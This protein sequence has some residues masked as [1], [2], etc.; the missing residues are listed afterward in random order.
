M[1]RKITPEL[2]K[3][4]KDAVNLVDIVSEH[5]VLRKSGSNHTGLCPFHSERSPSFSVSEQK[6]L[7]HCYGCKKGGDLVNFV[8]EIHTL[9]FVEAID[10]LAARAKI[11]LPK[12]WDALAGEGDPAVLER[13]KAALEKTQLAHKLNLFTAMFYR[14]QLPRSP[15]IQQYFAARGISS[16]DLH[17]SFYLG[18]APASWDALSRHMVEKQAP[19]GLA[20]EL[21]L[22]KPSQKQQGKDG[23]GHYDM[24]RN[25]AMFPILD[26]RGKVVGFGGRTLPT[27]QGAPDV[28]GEGPKYMNSSESPLF[29]KSKVAYGLFQAQK[30]IREADEIILVEG[31]FDVLALHA[32][33]FENVVATCGTALTP[34]HLALFK[35]LGSKVTVLFD[36]DRAGISATE[37]AME[38]GLDQ[39][40]VL[41]GASIPDGLDPD[42]VLFDGLTGKPR[43]DGRE[44][45]MAILAG[46][47][48]ILDARIDELVDSSRKGPEE[49]TQ[50]IKQVASWLG[51]FRD[52]VGRE[53]RLEALQGKLGVPRALL[54]K[55]L[56]HSG[57]SAAP[58]IALQTQPPRPAARPVAPQSPHPNQPARARPRTRPSAP[59]LLSRREVAMLQGLVF[60]GPA[61]EVLL[62]IR[63]QLPPRMTIS[64]LFDYPSVR[65]FVAPL[66]DEAGEWQ[67]FRADPESFFGEA[68][69]PQV[70]SIVMEA[71][72]AQELPIAE[73]DYR[74]ACEV[75]LARSWA[76]FSQQIKTAMADAEAKQDA[77]L[78]SKLMKEYL[79]VQRRMKEFSVSYDEA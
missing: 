78:H 50:A 15:H 33:G 43:P 4:I 5:V 34:D 42:E 25:R 70:R 52:P 75:G 60:L 22:I 65:A 23:P 77:G 27:P 56:S 24:F 44:R 36:G 32:A 13:R 12:D 54:D 16:P 40:L 6:Q 26:S 58:A 67:A 29:A 10:D 69:E 2:L 20:V 72:L 59:V 49:R 8:Q 62:R 9:S 28:G 71:L 21:G 3:K 14:Q 76:R 17:R 30:H 1:K 45:M 74:R 61:S 38:V 19:L 73:G 46:A 35:R 79:D 11:A 55:A 47:R 63:E 64:D 48:P 66:A 31:Y 57:G 68:I 41:S 37:R 53:V 51:R 7:Y 39:G 18:G